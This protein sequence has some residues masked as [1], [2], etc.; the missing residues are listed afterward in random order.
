[1]CI[2]PYVPSTTVLQKYYETIITITT[3]SCGNRYGIM[4]ARQTSA[5]NLYVIILHITN[6]RVDSVQPV[7]CTYKNVDTPKICV[8]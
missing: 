1:M 7:Q 4:P 8:P 6:A 2:C 3:V 5:R